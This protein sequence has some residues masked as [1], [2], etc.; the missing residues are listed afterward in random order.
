LTKTGVAVE[1]VILRKVLRKHFVLG[2]PTD[3]DRAW[4]KHFLSKNISAILRKKDFFNSHTR[5]HKLAPSVRRLR[6]SMSAQDI[7]SQLQ[8]L[9][10]EGQL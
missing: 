3:D 10:E 7:R 9:L 8:C 6:Q 1:K 4:G 2:R 5:L